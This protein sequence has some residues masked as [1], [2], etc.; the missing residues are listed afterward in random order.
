MVTLTGVPAESTNLGAF[1]GTL[2]NDTATIKGALQV[3]ET[4]LEA[5]PH[6]V[7]GNPT[8]IQFNQASQFAASSNLTFNTG[9]NI[10]KVTGQGQFDS[11]TGTDAVI[12]ASLADTGYFTVTANGTLT[13]SGESTF[14]QRVTFQRTTSEA[15]VLRLSNDDGTTFQP[16]L[17]A[18]GD[19]TTS[20][21]MNLTLSDYA[22][23]AAAAAGGIAVGQLYRNGSVVMIR[24][25]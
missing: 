13:N 17:T 15:V 24:V 3:L 21:T 2:I 8:E 1:S 7:Q 19:F 20:G 14:K 9:T 16:I 25:S 10:L 22:D 6:T 4:A 23:D 11:A 18:A 12:K 5:A